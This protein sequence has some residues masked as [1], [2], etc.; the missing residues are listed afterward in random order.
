M[1]VLAP[2]TSIQ[3]IDTV[4]GVAPATGCIAAADVGKQARVP[5]TASYVY[6]VKT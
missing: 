6:F 3:R 4:G 1:G 5:Y 2:V